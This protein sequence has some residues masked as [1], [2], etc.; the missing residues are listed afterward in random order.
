MLSIRYRWRFC[1]AQVM[2]LMMSWKLT[3]PERTMDLFE[4][5]EERFHTENT[6]ITESP[7]HITAEP[8]DD[9]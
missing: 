4:S 2:P 5:S 3:T 1:L 9:T 8:W 6:V 7:E